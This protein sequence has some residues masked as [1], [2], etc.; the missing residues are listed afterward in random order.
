MSIDF[1]RIPHSAAAV[2]NLATSGLR[3]SLIPKEDTLGRAAW[4]QADAQG[5]HEAEHSPAKVT[6]LLEACAP[7]R[8][9][10]VWDDSAER[11]G[12][13]IATARSWPMALSVPGAT[14]VTAW[15]ISSVT[16]AP[17]H[18][19]RGIARTLLT[20]ELLTAREAGCSIAMLTVTEATIYGRYGFGPAAWAA[21][22]EIATAGANWVGSRPAGRVQFITAES[23]LRSGPEVYERARA[24]TPGEVELSPYWWKVLLGL[25]SASTDEAAN[26]TVRAVRYDDED[27]VAQGIA[28][29]TVTADEQ[30]MA[31]G[32]LTLKF[33]VS[34]TDDAY[35]ALWQFLI[36]IDLV[37]TINAPLRA[38]DEPLP[39]Q[40]RDGRAA[41]KVG[42]RDHLWLRIIDVPAT[43]TARRYSHPDEFLLTITDTLG[44]AN[45]NVLLTIAED[46]S[47]TTCAHTG[48]VPHG[49][50][51]LTLTIAD[52][53]S[54]Y[55]GGVN[56]ETLASAGRLWEHTPH[57]A[58]RLERSF[59]STVTPRTGSWF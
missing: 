14:P 53:G 52:L 3:L 38:V 36:E 35:A 11:A 9:T 1:A 42:E 2:D 17:T 22:W 10:G 8:V 28:F 58:A 19:R 50:A 59:H 33:L 16:V 49:A 15:A 27:G 24:A 32:T 21:R 34:A 48:A 23:A 26:S 12:L 41:H 30:V 31:N 13:P 7:H 40:L 56:A 37:C 25:N 6:E 54:L 51:H 5:F 57:A 44:L 29:Y 18:R 4:L 55:L 45:G 47:A 43:L 39:W 20:S 46:G